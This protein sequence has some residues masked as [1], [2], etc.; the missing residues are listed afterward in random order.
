MGKDRRQTGCGQV[1]MEIKS[2]GLDSYECNLCPC[3]CLQWASSMRT[4]FLPCDAMHSAA[5]AVTP[6]LSLRLSRS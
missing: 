4:S 6:C 2:A 5:I 3:L 1:G